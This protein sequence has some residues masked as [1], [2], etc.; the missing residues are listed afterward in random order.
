[1]WDAD[2]DRLE[3][4]TKASH[5]SKS[6]GFSL[7]DAFSEDDAVLDVTLEFNPATIRAALARTL[8]AGGLESSENQ[9]DGEDGRGMHTGVSNHHPNHDRNGSAGVE[10]PD[11]SV[12][13]LDINASP[14]H[15]PGPAPEEWSRSTSY[16][17]GYEY[18]QESQGSVSGMES[19]DNFSRI[20]LS[21][22]VHDLESVEM[23]LE[24]SEEQVAQEK[25]EEGDTEEDDEGLFR[26]VH[27]DLS[28]GGKPRVEE[29]TVV[30]PEPSN[31]HT[32]DRD[33]AGT[34]SPK[35]LVPPPLPSTSNN[36]HNTYTPPSTSTPT[37][38]VFPNHQSQSQSVPELH[39]PI[40]YRRSAE[41]TPTNGETD[42]IPPDSAGNVLSASSLVSAS[43]ATTS[44]SIPAPNSTA[45]P[46]NSSRSEPPRRG[47]RPSRSVGPSALDKVISK[48]RPSFLP[49]KPKTEDLKH[50]ADWEAMMKQSRAVGEFHLGSLVWFLRFYASGGFKRIDLQLFSV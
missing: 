17:H 29:V 45:S 15:I 33:G 12:S 7:E 30:L 6:P 48:T 50:M 1:M 44:E 25:D 23:S 36:N 31:P 38:K 5:L 34:P 16:G 3:A 27:I 4:H 14:A 20:S 19:L 22:S 42:R 32:P 35:P 28:Q 40:T 39:S 18:R 2:D 46:P 47:H 13:T 43:S 8:A 41:D 26:A 10:D 24:P 9:T 11:A 49:P 21:D 37:S